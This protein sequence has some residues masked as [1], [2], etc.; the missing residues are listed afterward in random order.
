MPV[1]TKLLIV[2]FLILSRTPVLAN[3]TQEA[4]NAINRGD[5]KTAI[6][7]WKNLANRGN[8]AAQFNLGL[9]YLKGDGFKQNFSKAAKWFRLAAIQGNLE[10]QLKLGEMY[11][12][13]NGVPRDYKRA[14]KWYLYSSKQG[15]M[16]AQF[17]LG[18]MLEKG[19]GITKNNDKAIQ[20][21]KRSANHGHSGAQYKLGAMYDKRNTNKKEFKK[22]LKWYLKSGKNGNADAQFK[23]G[24]IFDQGI[25]HKKDKRKAFKWYSLA[26]E[27]GH[28]KAQ[29]HLGYLYENGRG[30][31]RNLE[32]AAKWYLL[33]AK[34]NHVPAQKNLAWMYVNGIGVEEDLNEAGKWYR[35]AETLENQ[36]IDENSKTIKAEL[37]TQK[38]KTKKS[39]KKSNE[40]FGLYESINSKEKDWLFKNH[41]LSL[42]IGTWFSTGETSWNH[43]ASRTSSIAGNPTSELIYENLESKIIE[44]Q[45]EI[46]LPHKVFLRTQFGFGTINDG[47]LVD[48]DFVS[49]AGAASFNASQSGPHRISKSHSNIDDDN[50]WYLNLDLGYKLWASKNND[51]FTRVFIGYQHWQ[52]KVVAIGEEQIECTS[53]GGG[54]PFCNSPGTITNV[55]QK[56]ITNKVRWD[57]LRIGLENS[58]RYSKKFWFD[59]DLAYIPISGLLNQDIHHLRTDLQQDPSFEMDGT[60]SGYNLEANLKYSLTKK[61]LLS[62]GYK[63]WKIKISDGTWKNLPVVGTQTVANLNDLSSSRQGVT[64]QLEY[65][66]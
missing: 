51:H 6:N 43:D 15:N 47:R 16:D 25:K 22:A 63:Y 54:S 31:E 8:N 17:N 29:F 41:K 21:F 39:D 9:M 42:A 1:K 33:S 10:A 52:E 46:K 56:I 7:I 19:E 28:P 61:L 48:S 53:F 64:A 66:F 32:K 12:N 4:L 14:A 58:F 23:I 44:I 50:M 36:P 59:L 3:E 20:W 60:G 62:V 13:G 2:L 37:H 11:F 40:E 38:I 49:A 5:Y 18:S 34:Q 65:L 35:Q 55:G 45:G 24:E 57:S 26:A 30:I 27:K